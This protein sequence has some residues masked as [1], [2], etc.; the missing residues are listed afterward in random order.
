MK[1]PAVARD[2]NASAPL[3]WGNCF[4]WYPCGAV[5]LQIAVGCWYS[6][7]CSMLLRNTKMSST[8]TDP[9]SSE[10]KCDLKANVRCC[11]SNVTFADHRYRLISKGRESSEASEQTNDK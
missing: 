4:G 1:L 2:F 5:P 3:G 8:K 10:S 7:I 9:N 6:S 11:C